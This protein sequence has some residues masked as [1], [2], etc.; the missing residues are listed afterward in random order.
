MSVSAAYLEAT[1]TM[2]AVAK[3]V[4]I[5]VLV[6]MSQMTVSEMNLENTTSSHQQRQHWLGEQALAWSKLPVVTVR[7]TMFQE[8]FLPLAAPAVRDRSRN[9]LPFELGKTCP[10]ALADV[11]AVV[12]NILAHPEPHIGRVYELIGPRSQDLHGVAKEFS[13]ALNREIPYVDVPKD[14]W[15]LGLKSASLPD[16]VHKHL[17]TMAELHRAVRYD[18]RSDGVQ[19]ITGRVPM[20][21]RNF[22]S[23][24]ADEFGQRRA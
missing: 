18:R 22:V 20:S 9:E 12:A 13:V 3:E 11:A 15:E 6:N 1:V 19:R 14:A 21:V 7:L 8:S 16:H 4:G 24:H 5:D 2:G 10:V 23:L 17:V